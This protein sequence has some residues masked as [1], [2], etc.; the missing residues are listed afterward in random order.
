MENHSYMKLI[1]MAGGRGEPLNSHIHSRPFLC[2]SLA[3]SGS[4]P[5][6]WVPLVIPWMLASTHPSGER[7]GQARV[8][9]RVKQRIS[10]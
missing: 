8:Q 2:Q 4:E 6:G 9:L 7:T 5:A 3:R 10:H 1:L